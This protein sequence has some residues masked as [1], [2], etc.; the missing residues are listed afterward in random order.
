MQISSGKLM[1]IVHLSTICALGMLSITA[2]D[3]SQTPQDLIVHPAGCGSSQTYVLEDS[4]NSKL[5]VARGNPPCAM[6]PQSIQLL[7]LD[8]QAF[9]VAK[10]DYYAC[11]GSRDIVDKEDFVPGY[12]VKALAASQCKTHNSDLSKAIISIRRS[13]IPLLVD[14]NNGAQ[15]ALSAFTKRPGDPTEPYVVDF[16]GSTNTNETVDAFCIANFDM[17]LNEGSDLRMQPDERNAARDC[18]NAYLR[19]VE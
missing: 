8:D 3:N 18:L 14:V 11:G 17:F 1:N 15:Q 7:V 2:C 13:R 12:V 16:I 10:G 4:K 6:I 9:G 5:W 19:S